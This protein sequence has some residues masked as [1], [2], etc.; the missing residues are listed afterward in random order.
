MKRW[1]RFS[2][3]LALV[4]PLTACAGEPENEKTAADNPNPA[5]VGTAGTAENI[6]RD[7]IEEQL[8]DGQHEVE[9]GRLAQQRASNA[10]VK[11][12]AQLMVRDHTQAGSDLKQIASKHNVALSTDEEADDHNDLRDR[13]AKLNGAEFDREYINAMVDDHEKAVNAVEGKA[14]DD[15]HAEVKAWAAK[16]L[17]TLRQH[18]ERAKEIQQSLERRGTNE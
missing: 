1:T 12:F 17:P 14:D 13:L 2:L 5:A 7:F 15:G 10:Q 6:D 4:L 11:E 16:T 18:L 3:A 8:A 9:L